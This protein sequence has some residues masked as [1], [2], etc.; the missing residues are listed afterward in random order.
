MA[1]DNGDAERTAVKQAIFDSRGDTEKD[2]R[3]LAVRAFT[4][5]DMDALMYETPLDCQ[6]WLVKT[7]VRHPDPRGGAGWSDQT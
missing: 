1:C 3:F 5:D 4:V 6:G 7:V 2:D